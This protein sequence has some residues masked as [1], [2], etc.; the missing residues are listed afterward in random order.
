[1]SL[2]RTSLFLAIFFLSFI[3]H[4]QIIGMENAEKNNNISLSKNTLEYL[5]Y[6][7]WEEVKQTEEYAVCVEVNQLPRRPSDPIYVRAYKKLHET[8][9]WQKYMSIGKEEKT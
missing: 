1:M 7:A 6:N 2:S 8:E 5:R 3:P 9:A 4:N